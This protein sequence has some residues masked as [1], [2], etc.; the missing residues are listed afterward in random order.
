MA[1]RE[2][3]WLLVQGQ[4]SFATNALLITQEMLIYV[5]QRE[6]KGGGAG[7][8]FTGCETPVIKTLKTND[9]DEN[10]GLWD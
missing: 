3:V 4:S 9:V 7:N 8:V 10:A 2:H 6:I 1:Q 5:I